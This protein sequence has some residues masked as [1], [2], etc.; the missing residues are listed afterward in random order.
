M[1]AENMKQS[2]IA[3]NCMM[4]LMRFKYFYLNVN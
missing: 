1:Q 2:K 4:K 3:E